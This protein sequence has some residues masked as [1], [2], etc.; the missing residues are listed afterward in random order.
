MGLIVVL[1]L[2]VL[3]Q[4]LGGMTAELGEVVQLAF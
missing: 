3:E 2:L 4:V 1:E